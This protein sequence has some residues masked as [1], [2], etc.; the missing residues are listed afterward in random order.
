MT[1]ISSVQFHSE[2]SHQ[3]SRH[4]ISSDKLAMFHLPHLHTLWLYVMNVIDLLLKVVQMLLTWQHHTDQTGNW[5]LVLLVGRHTFNCKWMLKSF[6]IP[7]W[8]SCSCY[9]SVSLDTVSCLCING[10]CRGHS[11]RGASQIPKGLFYLTI[12]PK[13]LS[14]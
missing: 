5:V 10:S 7:I 14:S 12:V 8:R 6:S 2:H 11:W 1:C 4:L 3:P 13:A 9:T